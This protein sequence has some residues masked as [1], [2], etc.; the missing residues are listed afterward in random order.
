MKTYIWLSSPVYIH[1]RAEVNQ[2]EQAVWGLVDNIFSIIGQKGWVEWHAMNVVGVC[3]A[4]E[5]G[6]NVA[7]LAQEY[8]VHT[9]HAEESA[10]AIAMVIFIVIQEIIHPF[11]KLAD[12]WGRVSKMVLLLV[13][14]SWHKIAA[15][16][17]VQEV[18]KYIFFLN[19]GSGTKLAKR[20]IA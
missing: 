15:I 17:L 20:K 2:L 14:Q 8:S 4:K 1:E 11:V 16:Q 7:V 18:L 6:E 10:T 3:G 19:Y 9:I 5:D 12:V 13:G